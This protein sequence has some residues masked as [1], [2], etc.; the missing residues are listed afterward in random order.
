MSAF[1]CASLRPCF[2]SCCLYVA[3]LPPKYCCLICLRRSSICLSVTSTPRSFAFCSRSACW[4][5]SV[6]AWLLIVAYS[7]VPCFGNFRCCCSNDAF[8][9]DMRSSNCSFVIVVSPTTATSFD[10]S[11]AVLSPPPPQAATPSARAS[12]T[13]TNVR[14]DI[15]MRKPSARFTQLD[16]RPEYHRPVR[17]PA[18][19]RPFL[20]S[21][22]VLQTHRRRSKSGP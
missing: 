10:S 4:T 13:G 9:V 12:T 18:R 6:T 19:T 5:S 21:F 2:F 1:T 22:H 7:D 17:P 15:F 11:L 20:G 16:G 8:A 3:S 14:R